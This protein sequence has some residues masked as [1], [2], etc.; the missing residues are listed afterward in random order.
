MKTWT[1][2]NVWP[3][4]GRHSN[5]TKQTDPKQNLPAVLFFLSRDASLPLTEVPVSLNACSLS[6]V[7]GGFSESEFYIFLISKLSLLI[8]LWL[9]PF[10]GGGYLGFLKS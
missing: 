3:V 4:V 9:K 10:F 6:F 8:C 7:L 5:K 2:V 1:P